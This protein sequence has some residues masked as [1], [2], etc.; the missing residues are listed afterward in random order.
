[1]RREQ[2]TTTKSNPIAGRP[3]P[4]SSPRTVATTAWADICLPQGQKTKFESCVTDLVKITE[5]GLKIMVEK[6]RGV[7]SI[8]GTHLPWRCS[9][10]PSTRK[11]P[12]HFFRVANSAKKSRRN[13]TGVS[14]RSEIE[15]FSKR[16]RV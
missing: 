13:L 3:S 1:M 5:T 16:N 12:P 11:D 14:G 10:Q 8:G 2:R 15:S 6:K 9:G 4:C 7:R